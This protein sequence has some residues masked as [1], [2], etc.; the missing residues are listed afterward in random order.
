[1][2]SLAAYSLMHR[3][4]AFGFN[5]LRSDLKTLNFI[6][7]LCLSDVRR[8][9]GVWTGQNRGKKQTEIFKRD[10]E[11]GKTCILVHV[12]ALFNLL[13][14]QTALCFLSLPCPQH[15]GVPRPGIESMP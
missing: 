15:V 8:E 5:S 1:M 3:G 11:E 10:T 2:A 13:F 9:N 12:K 4:P 7:S 14:K 6:L